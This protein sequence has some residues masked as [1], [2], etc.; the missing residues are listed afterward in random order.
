MLFFTETNKWLKDWAKLWLLLLSDLC[1]KGYSC[2]IHEISILPQNICHHTAPNSWSTQNLLT[3][4]IVLQSVHFM[5]C[6]KYSLLGC[7]QCWWFAIHCLLLLLPIVQWATVNGNCCNYH[8]NC[9]Y[10]FVHCFLPVLF[11][12][13]LVIFYGYFHD[14]KLNLF[15]INRVQDSGFRV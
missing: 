2:T 13:I 6:A 15:M 3:W 5:Y 9:W 11:I 1:S 7:N 14:Q 10:F 12:V 8:S 4:K